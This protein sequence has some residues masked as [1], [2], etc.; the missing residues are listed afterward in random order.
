MNEF[1]ST[2]D[3]RSFLKLLGLSSLPVFMP[4]AEIAAATTATS[5]DPAEEI[6]FVNFVSDGLYFSPS[7]YI[8]KLDQ[9]HKATPIKGDRYGNGGTTKEL[10]EAF[11]KLTGKEKAIFFPTGTMANQVV[12]KIL[13]GENTKIIVPENSHIYR[14]EA[15]AAQSVHGKRLVPAGQG[16]PYFTLKELKETIAYHDSGEVFKS[17]LGTVVIESPVRRADGAAVP[18]EVMKEITSHCREKGY[19]THLDGARIHIASAYTGVS[20]ATYA[21]QFDTIYISLYKYLNASGGAMLCG[22]AEVIDKMS[23]Q[24]KIFGGTVYQTW[25]ASSMALHYLNG[26]EERWKQVTQVAA[27]LIAGLNKIKGIS[28]APIEHGTNIYNLKA[29][30]GID[31]KK[32]GNVL[33]PDHNIG[34]GGV[35]EEG[36][37]K[38]QVNESLLLRKPEDL[39]AAW[40]KSIEK[41]RA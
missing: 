34:I 29:D 7:E 38:F 4:G 40:K 24:I 11:A 15:D 19:K 28:I 9:I 2:K 5:P 12:I 23:H 32:V 17:G 36:V 14:D 10:E 25:G 30:S 13:N 21:A 16:N 8:Q 37:I 39:L 18:L 41:V 31:L 33:Y 22:P 6:P 1:K 27:Q 35:N 3:R 20:I 26:I